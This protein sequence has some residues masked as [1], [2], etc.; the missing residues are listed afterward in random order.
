MKF[1]GTKFIVIV[2][3]FVLSAVNLVGQDVAITQAEFEKIDT[4]SDKAAEG[5]TLRRTTIMEEVVG[6]IV[7]TEKTRC[8]IFESIP[9]DRSRITDIITING[10]TKKSE[11]IRIGPRSWI[12]T[13]DGAWT[14]AEDLYGAA[15]AGAALV[16]FESYK[17][18]GKS[19]LSGVAVNEYEKVI[20]W[21]T[22][23]SSGSRR[24]EII[25]TRIWVDKKG[26]CLKEVYETE[27]VNTNN[28]DRRTVTSEYNPKALKIEAPIK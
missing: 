26:L 24:E 27:N 17:S 25:T 19:K 12:R 14:K 8:N 28:I 4:T 5:K 1:Q 10:K 22:Y 3:F 16:S 15:N 23:D 11:T 18:K 6:G 9:P 2:A 21:K 13:N 7:S 20:K